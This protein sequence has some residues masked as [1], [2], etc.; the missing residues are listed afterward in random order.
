MPVTDLLC[1]NTHTD[2]SGTS[3]PCVEHE[4]ERSKAP[5]PLNMPLTRIPT[6]DPIG[7]YIKQL[8]QYIDALLSFVESER[9]VPNT[10]LP[11]KCAAP[12]DG[13]NMTKL[14]G[15][16]LASWLAKI[17]YSYGTAQM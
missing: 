4:G 6:E 2:P 8:L 17:L 16:Q 13:K 12:T 5:E 14:S 3:E 7:S 10:S 1:I 9:E 15:R 11:A